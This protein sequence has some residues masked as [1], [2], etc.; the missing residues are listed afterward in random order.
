M[1]RGEAVVSVISILC[2]G[3]VGNNQEFLH[4]GESEPVQLPVPD[5]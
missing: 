2:V 4:P 3:G 1:S 5:G